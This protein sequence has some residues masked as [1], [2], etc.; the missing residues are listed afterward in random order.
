MAP[1]TK[2][3]IRP[4]FFS[5]P[6]ILTYSIMP[7]IILTF[8]TFMPP[9]PISTARFTDISP[10][11]SFFPFFK[12]CLLAWFFWAYA[13]KTKAFIFGVAKRTE[14]YVWHITPTSTGHAANRIYLELWPDKSLYRRL[15][16][17][18]V[19]YQGR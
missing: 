6:S 7:G 17:L 2:N 14:L 16:F 8:C 10:F 15:S 19:L 18:E 5:A 12:V 13:I 11:V 1:L 4:T 9:N 3:P